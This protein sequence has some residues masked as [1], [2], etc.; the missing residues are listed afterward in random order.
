MKSEPPERFTILVVPAEGQGEIRQISLKRWHVYW[1]FR[2]G[3]SFVL[4]LFL[5]AMAQGWSL[6]RALTVASLKADNLRLRTQVKEVDSRLRQLQALTTRLQG[7]DDRLKD[8]EIRGLLPG[9]GPLS[10]EE[11]AAR[12]AWLAGEEPEGSAEADLE[13]EVDRLEDA[14][15][16]VDE[17][18]LSKAL[19]GF[20]GRESSLP[21][22]WP[23]EGVITSGFG[24]RHSPFTGAWTM[25]GGIDIGVP[26]GEPI[27]AANRG[28]V[29]FSGWDSGHGQMVVVDHGNGVVTRYCHASQLLVSEGDEVET[30]DVLAMVG[31]T[32]MSTGPHLHFDLILDGE[33]V[34]PLDYLP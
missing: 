5:G 2:V 12:R 10:E 7:Y 11:M 18:H 32:G 14:L 31:S 17:T 6:P 34:D 23:V 15:E 22:I 28:T 13:L 16:Q 1:A 3:V 30:G 8:L 25:H 19:S 9:T 26:Y 20:F 21:Q 4:L 27:L 24:Y 33:R 29:R